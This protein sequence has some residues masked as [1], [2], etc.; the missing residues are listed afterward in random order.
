MISVVK[1]SIKIKA[2]R[3]NKMAILVDIYLSV[4]FNNVKIYKHF[5]WI[6]V[7]LLE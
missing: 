7:A 1:S 3:Q 2:Y 5:C 4:S 6:K